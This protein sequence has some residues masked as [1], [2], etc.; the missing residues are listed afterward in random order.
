MRLFR[1]T[2][3]P[4]SSRNSVYLQSSLLWILSSHTCT[5]LVFGRSI[6]RTCC[7]SGERPV[8]TGATPELIT[9]WVPIAFRCWR[10]NV[11]LGLCQVWYRNQVRIIHVWWDHPLIRQQQCPYLFGYESDAAITHFIFNHLI[12]EIFAF[13]SA[14]IE[15]RNG[16]SSD[17][18]LA[19]NPEVGYANIISFSYRFWGFW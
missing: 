1:V 10:F 13:I 17:L 7:R 15:S 19:L 18:F 3:V 9:S 14:S 16:L 12:A 2:G 8:P 5:N 6:L 4:Q 11:A